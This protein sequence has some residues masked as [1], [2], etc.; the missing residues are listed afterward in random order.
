MYIQIYIHV[1][2]RYVSLAAFA[3]EYMFLFFGGYVWIC[4]Y[5]CVHNVCVCVCVC[6]DTDT[7]AGGFVHTQVCVCSYIHT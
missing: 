6:I 7:N 2:S 5:V 4:G 1:G 3:F